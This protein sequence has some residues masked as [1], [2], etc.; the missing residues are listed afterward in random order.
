MCP[1]WQASEEAVQPGGLAPAHTLNHF[2]QAPPAAALHTWVTPVFQKI[3][4]NRIDLTFNFG[5]RTGHVKNSSKSLI[6]VYCYIIYTVTVHYV[7]AKTLLSPGAI[8]AFTRKL[9]LDT[10]S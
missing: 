6:K 9:K 4:F 2:A 8:Y 10:T 7:K 5:L 3:N 1:R